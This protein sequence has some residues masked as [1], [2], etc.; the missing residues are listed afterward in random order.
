MDK[1]RIGGL[2]FNL[3]KDV[4]HTADPLTESREQ[5]L[6]IKR[7]THISQFILVIVLA[8]FFVYYL[9]S[10]DDSVTFQ[11]DKQQLGVSSAGQPSVFIPYSDIIALS[12]ERMDEF[13]L[14]TT[15]QMIDLDNSL[16]GRFFND[17]FGEYILYATTAP[18][19]L[20]VVRYTGGMLVFNCKTYRETER[21]FRQL[22]EQ[23][24]F[25]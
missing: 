24:G 16:S 19:V 25:N 7:T 20:I 21:A 14:G 17:L 13:H 15:V 2:P 4:L 8:V 1:Q 10:V 22:Q 11:M 9:T 3:N 12:L 6:K 23:V 5:E 18:S